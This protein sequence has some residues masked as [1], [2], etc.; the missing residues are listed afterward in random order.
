MEL[1]KTIRNTFFP[2]YGKRQ[3]LNEQQEKNHQIAADIIMK[4]TK[5]LY[6]EYT[7]NSLYSVDVVP[8]ENNSE[9]ILFNF[10]TI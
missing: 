5:D 9:Q 3:S 4:Q 10:S 2:E 8:K 1:I 6:P 7:L